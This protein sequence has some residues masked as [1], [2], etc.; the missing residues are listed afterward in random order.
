MPS[1]SVDLPAIHCPVDAVIQDLMPS[2][3]RNQR[4]NYEQFLVTVRVHRIL[5]LSVFDCCLCA[6][7]SSRSVDVGIQDIANVKKEKKAPKTL[8]KTKQSLVE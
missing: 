1:S 3:I 8:R 6:H 7:A 2:V 5:Q 4:G